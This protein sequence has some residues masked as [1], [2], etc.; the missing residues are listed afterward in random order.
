MNDCIDI[1]K[2]FCTGRDSVDDP[3]EEVESDALV[4]KRSPTPTLITR[5]GDA[6]FF[7]NQGNVFDPA[8]WRRRDEDKPSD[9]VTLRER[10]RRT[11]RELTIGG[12]MGA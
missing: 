9:Y 12:R 5:I 6:Y 10:L 4:T 8:R 1:P 7:L 11:K 3:L 2:C